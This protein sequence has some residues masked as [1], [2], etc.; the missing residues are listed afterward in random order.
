MQLDDRGYWS[1]P[2]PMTDE[3]VVIRFYETIA[4]PLTPPDASL[5]PGTFVELGPGDLPPEPLDID[6]LPAPAK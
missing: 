3:S 1:D 5:Q 4:N 2:G 6:Q